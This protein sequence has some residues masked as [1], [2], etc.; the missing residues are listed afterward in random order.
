MAR[1]YD[2]R[3]YKKNPQHVL[4]HSH[5][6]PGERGTQK[7]YRWG[8]GGV[9]GFQCGHNQKRGGGHR[10]IQLFEKGGS[11]KQ[12]EALE[13][14]EGGMVRKGGVYHTTLY[15]SSHSMHARKIKNEMSLDALWLI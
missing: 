7:I 2:A 1:G 12:G 8:G 6:K 9:E 3:L 14:A 15:I 4:Y 13:K 10:Q 11:Q 5:L